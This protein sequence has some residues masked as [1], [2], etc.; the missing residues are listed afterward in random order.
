MRVLERQA[1]TLEN[2]VTAMQGQLTVMR[3]S[4]KQNERAVKVAERSIEVAQKNAISAQR[5]YVS[6][7]EASVQ[8]IN[9]ATFSLMIENFGNTWANDAEIFVVAEVR[10]CAPASEVNPS[11]WVA[12][13]LI[14]PRQQVQKFV[15]CEEMLTTEQKLLILED[16]K[17]RVYCSG[18]IRYR[19]FGTMHSTK[20]CFQQRFGG[21]DTGPCPTGNEAD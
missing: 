19:T 21:N 8:I 3:E 18:I 16:L 9:A 2:Q 20:F 1:E 13:G 10:D 11:S 5:A 4:L 17:L 15:P 7:A 14:A 6:V 12:L